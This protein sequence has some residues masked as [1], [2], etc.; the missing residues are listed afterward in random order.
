MSVVKPEPESL[1]KQFTPQQQLWF[2]VFSPDSRHVAASGL[3]VVNIGHYA[4]IAT[5]LSLVACALTASMYGC[6]AFA[7]VSITGTTTELPNCL[8]A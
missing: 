6:M 5:C 4:T 1:P 7:I 2:C 8:Y 3:L